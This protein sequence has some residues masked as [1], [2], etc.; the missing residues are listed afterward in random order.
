MWFLHRITEITSNASF[1]L[2]T[3]IQQLCKCPNWET[4]A[5]GRRSRP[6]LVPSTAPP[7]HTE[8]SAARTF[9]SPPPGHPSGCMVGSG[10]PQLPAEGATPLIIPELFPGLQVTR[11]KHSL[12]CAGTH[13]C[14]FLKPEEKHLNC[15]K[16]LPA[17]YSLRLSFHDSYLPC[18][19]TS[20]SP[21]N[22]TVA[23]KEDGNV[24]TSSH[25]RHLM[26]LQSLFYIETST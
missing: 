11:T 16:C 20:P 1:S 3:E 4:E 19:I 6:R 17:V 26:F 10:Q 9:I 5:Q 15:R 7:A 18:G 14:L 8:C 23:P 21:T 12:P 22:V 25:R 24:S 13:G 2:P